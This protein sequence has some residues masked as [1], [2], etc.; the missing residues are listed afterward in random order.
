[1]SASMAVPLT[2]SVAPFRMATIRRLAE[3][4]WADVLHRMESPARLRLNG[5]SR[6]F[7]LFSPLLGTTDT[8]SD[9]TG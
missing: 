7:T 5:Y 8:T 2:T 6:Q 9:H 1:M 3:A 4:A